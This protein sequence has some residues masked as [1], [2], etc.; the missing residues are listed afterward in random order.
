MGTFASPSF[1]A[2]VIKTDFD[3]SVIKIELDHERNVLSITE[4]S[5]ETLAFSRREDH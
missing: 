2:S 3:A 4:E 1:G 5:G